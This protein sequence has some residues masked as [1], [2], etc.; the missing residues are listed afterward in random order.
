MFNINKNPHPVI[1]LYFETEKVFSLF[2][3][4]ILQTRKKFFKFAPTAF[5]SCIH[6]NRLDSLSSSWSIYPMTELSTSY[7]RSYFR[8]SRVSVLKSNLQKD[9]TLLKLHPLRKMH[10]LMLL[11]WRIQHLHSGTSSKVQIS[12][13][14]SVSLELYYN[15]HQKAN[16]IPKYTIHSTRRFMFI[17]KQTDTAWQTHHSLQY[18]EVHT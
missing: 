16:L 17:H 4:K 1:P 10:V 5:N 3:G 11:G 13:A 9:R 6:T 15:F 2:I 18:I 7:P 8:K 14:C 12:W